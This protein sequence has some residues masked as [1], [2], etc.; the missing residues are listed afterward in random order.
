RRKGRRSTPPWTSATRTWAEVPSTTTTGSAWRGRARR[1][2]HGYASSRCAP[3]DPPAPPA[4]GLRTV[5]RR[6]A[7]PRHRR[8]CRR[9]LGRRR[10]PAPRAALPGSRPAALD[11]VPPPRQPDRALLAP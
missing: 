3:G 4:A 8:Q 11:H 7:G 5:D 10:G 9:V 1:A 6:D 2:E